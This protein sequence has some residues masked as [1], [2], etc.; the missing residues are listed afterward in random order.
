MKI[1]ETPPDIGSLFDGVD[2]KRLAAI[3]ASDDAA[4]GKY[5]HWSEL[6][7]LDPPEGLSLEEWWLGIKLARRIASH[8]LPLRDKVGKPFTYSMPDEAQRA[9]H[10]VDQGAAGRIS[11]SESAIGAGNR[12]RYILSS[13]IEE[14]ITSSQLEGASTSRKVAKEM[15]RSGRAPRNRSERMIV[16][17]Y[18]AMEYIRRRRDDPLDTEFLLELHEIVAHGT[19][20][21]EDGRFQRPGEERVAVYSPEGE[22]IHAPPHAEERPARLEAM[23]KF[24]NSSDE[25]SGGRSS[26][27]FMHPVVRAALLHFWI[28][29]DHPFADGNGRVARAL[30]YWSMLRQGYWLA[31]FLTISS[32]LKNAP[33]QYATSYLFTETDE[34]DTTYFI[35]Y[36]LNVILRAM[37]ELEAY[38]KRKMEETR[39]MESLIKKDANLNSRQT[40]LLAHALRNPDAVYTVKKHGDFHSI[41]PA[42]ARADLDELER[43][44]LLLKNKAGRA[45]RYFPVT[46]LA[47]KLDTY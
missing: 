28:G 13:L 14:S 29:Y 24:A 4:G 9:V 1:P 42:T 43:R 34:G 38:L 37:E 6:R 31:E 12:D 8:V 7:R 40:E 10:L 20:D 3:V 2:P 30:F 35:L 11:V 27:I 22:I 36:Q 47:G 44:G 39:R 46:D 19:L 23:Y 18:R 41:A 25:A 26:G 33:G 45:F 5:R 15:L 32:I 16:N 17:N 21:D